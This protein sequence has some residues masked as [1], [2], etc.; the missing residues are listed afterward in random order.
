M[1]V[2]YSYVRFSHQKQSEG[3][4]LRRQ[5]EDGTSWIKKNGHTAGNLSFQDLGVSA[6]RGENE[7]GGSLN[8]F[9]DAV[10]DGRVQSGS[11]LLVENL[12]RLSRQEIGK[13]FDLFMEILK[14]GV[15]IAVLRPT[16]IIYSKE[17]MNDLVNLL[18]PL[19]SFHLSHLESKNKSDR[20]KATWEAK[21]AAATKGV[22]FD[23]RCPSWIEWD[24][25]S[26]TFIKKDGWEA[27][28]FIFQKTLDGWGQT[29]I[30]N[31]LQ[32]TYAP[33]GTSGRWNS[34]F[35]QKIIGDVS[36][37]GIRQPHTRSASGERIAAGDPI[38]DYYPRVVDEA[39][40][41]RAQSARE[42]RS[43]HRG[44]STNFINLFYG[45]VVNANDGHAMHAASSP[46]HKGPR[47]RRL[48]SYGRI[49]EIPGSD[50]VTVHY[51][52]F[53]HAV[54]TFINEL[55]IEDIIPS[56][57]ADA[58]SIKQ[59]EH[60][61]IEAQLSRLEHAVQT[62][63]DEHLQTVIKSIQTLEARR[64]QL[65]QEIDHL[66]V[67]RLAKVPLTEAK[68]VIDLLASIAPD[69]QTNVKEKLKELLPTFIDS[70]YVKPEKFKNRVY[71]IIQVNFK[72]GTYRHI[73]LGPTSYA[74]HEGDH[75]QQ[76]M[77]APILDL[78]NEE[79]KHWSMTGPLRH[80][81]EYDEPL[82]TNIPAIVGHAIELWLRVAGR[83]MTK[84]SFRVVPSKLQRF[85]KVVG[86]STACSDLN[87]RI[88]RKWIRRLN[89]EIASGDIAFATARVAYSRAREFVS[90][91]VENEIT[92]DWDELHLPPTKV[93][94]KAESS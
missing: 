30:L 62:H 28:P 10:R 49:R 76:S 85:A 91:L 79:S 72:S 16:E 56:P 58:L 33:I 37:R 60:A 4:S 51:D 87:K 65:K 54:L 89:K 22:P 12:D 25:E 11:I 17:S 27:I 67:V 31:A 71:A 6:F 82:P 70:I 2:V 61:G 77:L 19:T 13:A 64:Q 45:L 15:K 42:K 81:E 5:I 26:E 1:A 63:G 39:T 24:D 57:N 68:S 35:V 53:E 50:S 36:V 21:R 20:L 90:W 94:K 44:P 92:E 52:C 69:Q 84:E 3:D 43:D 8:A 32:T 23:K 9:L 18:I 55:S 34:S 41:H 14:S 80:A 66:E 75:F 88:W 83:R 78:R 59:E 40:W 7:H 46:T 29:R 48:R 86:D 47:V 38:E 93:L 73:F 74:S